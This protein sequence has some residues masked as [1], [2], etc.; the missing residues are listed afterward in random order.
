M[1]WWVSKQIAALFGLDI[2][3]VQKRV[4]LAVMILVVVA[5]IVAGLWLR[6]CFK[7]TPKLDI[8]NIEKINKANEKERLKELEQTIVENQSVVRT[9]DKRNAIAEVSE[10]EKQLQI[11]IKIEEVNQKIATAKAQGRDVT[12]PELECMLVPENCK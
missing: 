9:V 10:A 2:S 4:L 6:S 12:G 3:V 8:K 11:Q 1:I 5:V 7:S